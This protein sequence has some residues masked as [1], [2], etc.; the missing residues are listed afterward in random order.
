VGAVERT[1]VAGMI[2]KD[3]EVVRKDVLSGRCFEKTFPVWCGISEGFLCCN[4]ERAIHGDATF[5]ILF[6]WSV[7]WSR[8]SGWWK[9]IRERREKVRVKSDEREV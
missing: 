1:P 5:W 7:R 6:F 8:L 9:S 4:I 2:K 3:E